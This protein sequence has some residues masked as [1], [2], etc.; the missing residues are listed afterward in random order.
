MD[1]EAV[2]RYEFQSLLD[3]GKDADLLIRVQCAVFILIEDAHEIFNRADLGEIM[4][5]CLVLLEDHLQ[6]LFC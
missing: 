1:L 2:I 3:E 5:V 6:H 4:E